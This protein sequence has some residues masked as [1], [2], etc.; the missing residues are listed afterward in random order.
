MILKLYCILESLGHF[1]L[2]ARTEEISMPA[3]KP[4]SRDLGMSWV[5]PA[6]SSLGTTVLDYLI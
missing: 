5:I 3:E 1:A 4:A 2:Q 6:C